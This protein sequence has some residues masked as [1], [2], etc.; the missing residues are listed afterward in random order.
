MGGK[1]H[2]TKGKTNGCG[3]GTPES[4]VTPV[5]SLLEGPSQDS[6]RASCNSWGRSGALVSSQDIHEGLSKPLAKER[7]G[8]DWERIELQTGI[9]IHDQKAAHEHF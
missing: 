5:P 4:E 3:S 9:E 1:K 8:T 7:L 2:A 6:A